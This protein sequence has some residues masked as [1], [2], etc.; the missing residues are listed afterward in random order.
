MV[1]QVF[2][3]EELERKLKGIENKLARQTLRKAMV[4]AVQP[5]LQ[6]MRARAPLGK[7][8][9]KTYK[10]RRVAPS[11]LRRKIIVRSSARAGRNV[12]VQIGVTPEA[13]YGI[14]FYDF[15]PYTITTR[16]AR[17]GRRSNAFKKDRRRAV[18]IKP[19]T[20]R[21]VPWFTSVYDRNLPKI[22]QNFEKALRLEIDKVIGSGR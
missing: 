3:F 19:Y 11:F 16:R 18:S 20:L 4:R 13:F 6:I 5:T 12:T 22:E 2:G 7:K 10:G 15:G 1:E 9:H 14:Q 21:K 8:A 17:R